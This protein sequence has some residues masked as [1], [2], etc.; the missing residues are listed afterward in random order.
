MYYIPY[1]IR[2]ILDDIYCIPFTV[3]VVVGPLLKKNYL[4]GRYP[5]ELRQTVRRAGR[6]AKLA[7]LL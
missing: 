1:A 3:N 5:A 6:A 7:G 2:Y 4:A